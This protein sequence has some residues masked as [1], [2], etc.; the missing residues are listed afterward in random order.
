MEHVVSVVR[1]ITP[2]A[3]DS[4]PNAVALSRVTKER[5]EKCDLIG[6]LCLLN[7]LLKKVGG[8]GLSIV[9]TPMVK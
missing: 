3:Y 6:M 8:K 7:R 4:L 5:K 2:H 9:Y 1:G